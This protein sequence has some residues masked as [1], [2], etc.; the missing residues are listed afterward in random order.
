MR[1]SE[2]KQRLDTIAIVISIIAIIISLCSS[3]AHGQVYEYKQKEYVNTNY[4]RTD[5]DSYKPK[6]NQHIVNIDTAWFKS[7]V[8]ELIRLHAK[9]TISYRKYLDTLLLKM[10]EPYVNLHWYGSPPSTNQS[11]SKED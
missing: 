11:I 3:A 4:W 9:D 5:V 8:N 1:Q 10:V 6:G 7:T 2:L